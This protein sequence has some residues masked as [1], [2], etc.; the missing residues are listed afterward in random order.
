MGPTT[1]RVLLSVAV[2]LAFAGMADAAY[3]TVVH[4][5][6]QPIVCSGIGD[7][8]LVNSSRY[9]EFAGVPVALLGLGAYAALAAL[10]GAAG[11]RGDVGLLAVAWGVAL[12]GVLF[13]GY[14]TYIE[15]RVLE[16]ICPYCV[17][18]AALLTAIFAVLSAALW[19]TH[20]RRAASV[21]S[22]VGF[23]E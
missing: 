15:L 23:A 21:S 1:V 10:G 8:E 16:A 18:S 14:L 5:A 4:Y 12:A 3:L 22:S 13:S 17:V 11:V 20:S 9:A 2:V 6:D 19:R 7:C